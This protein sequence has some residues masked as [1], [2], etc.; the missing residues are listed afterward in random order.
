MIK[1]LNE[2]MRN[3][4]TIL[5]FSLK[6]IKEKFIYKLFYRSLKFRFF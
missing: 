6:L 3:I 2:R 5:E 4:I 1:K